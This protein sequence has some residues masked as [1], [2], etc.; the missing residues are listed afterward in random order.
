[1]AVTLPNMAACITAKKK[2]TK[3][4]KNTRVWKWF[5]LLA[6]ICHV[7]NQK[8]KNLL[9]QARSSRFLY[10]D[11]RCSYIIIKILTEEFDFEITNFYNKKLLYH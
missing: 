10:E 11:Y 3:Y 4:S 7:H 2:E 5:N 8:Y 6:D 9:T 1:M